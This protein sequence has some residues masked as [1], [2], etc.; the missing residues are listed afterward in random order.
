VNGK[1]NPPRQEGI[2]YFPDKKPLSAHLAKGNIKEAIAP[3]FNDNH[4]RG[5]RRMMGSYL[6][7]DPRGLS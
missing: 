4:F 5:K 7:G 6:I 3:G 1:I 2:F